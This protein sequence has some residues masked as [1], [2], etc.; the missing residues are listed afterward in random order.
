MYAG[1]CLCQKVKYTLLSEPAKISHCHCTLCQKQHGAAF[2]SYAS[3][4]KSAFVYTAGEE[5]L[6]VYTSSTSIQRKF[7]QFCGSNIE[8]SDSIDYPNQVSIA[9]ATLDT[10][11]KPENIIDIYTDTQACWLNQK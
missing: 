3:L 2:A 10:L 4:P 8:W 9:I 11:Y 1:S 7:C 5:A 6:T